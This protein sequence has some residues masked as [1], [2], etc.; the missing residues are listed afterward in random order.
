[1]LGLKLNHV[2]KRGHW[3]YII[4]KLGHE[5]THWIELQ[6]FKENDFVVRMW[7]QH[8]FR[9]VLEGTPD[10]IWTIW[11]D[12]DNR[13][14]KWVSYG[15]SRSDTVARENSVRALRITT[16]PLASMPL[17][18]LNDKTIWGY[19]RWKPREIDI[20]SIL[21]TLAW[22]FGCQNWSYISNVVIE[23]SSSCWWVGYSAVVQ[24]DFFVMIPVFPS[25][26]LWSNICDCW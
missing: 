21:K 1:M 14:I 18:Y 3:K 19:Y 9:W 5:L 22:N 10:I 12:N 2:S 25:L 13:R 24:M 26:F 4:T 11:L 15:Y 20:Y 23:S 16:T 7:A 8:E 6:L 17:M